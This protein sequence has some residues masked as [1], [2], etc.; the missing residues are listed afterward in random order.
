MDCVHLRHGFTCRNGCYGRY[1]LSFTVSN[2]H[3]RTPLT[4]VASACKGPQWITGCLLI[5]WKKRSVM[6]RMETRPA[7]NTKVEF[8]CRASC[9]FKPLTR[10]FPI[11][12]TAK[13]IA[14][15]LSNFQV[16]VKRTSRLPPQL[17][18]PKM[19]SSV[20][21]TVYCLRTTFLTKLSRRPTS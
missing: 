11:P 6:F 10:S 17:L 16:I 12:F 5:N 13:K 7:R 8:P 15:D 20:A 4:I 14:I 21:C 2:G 9:E 1:Q 3:N 18:Q 19:T